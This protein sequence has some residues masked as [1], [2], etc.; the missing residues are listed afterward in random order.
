MLQSTNSQLKGDK[1]LKTGW[2]LPTKGRR[3]HGS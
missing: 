2:I 3:L 1:K